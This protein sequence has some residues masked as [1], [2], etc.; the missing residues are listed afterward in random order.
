MKEVNLIWH[1]FVEQNNKHLV[2]TLVDIQKGHRLLRTSIT[3][4]RTFLGID[5]VH[6]I[7]ALSIASAV[8]LLFLHIWVLPIVIAFSALILLQVLK[9]EATNAII[10]NALKSE[11]FY[12]KAVNS[13]ILK[14]LA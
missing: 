2:K 6:S 3:F 13:K 5:T 7:I 9:E 1:D 10:K 8:V 14:V 12:Y 4:N 11:V